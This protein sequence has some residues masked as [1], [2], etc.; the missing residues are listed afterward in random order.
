MSKMGNVTWGKGK[1]RSMSHVPFLHFTMK[2]YYKIL[3][4]EKS[5]TDDDI[6]KAYRKLAHQYHPDK[7]GG[8]EKRFKEI[9]EAYQVIGNSDKRK[10]YDRFGAGAFDEMAGEGFGGFDPFGGN[11]GG[12]G[13]G[14]DPGNMEDMGG[15]SD[16]FDMFF[17][18]LGVKRRKTY[19]KGS[20]LETRVAITLEEAYAGVKKSIAIKTF[21]RCE[22]C[23]GVGH[24]PDVGFDKCG[25]CDGKGE[26]RESKSGFFGS[27]S[28]VRPCAKCFGT[29]QIPKKIC[30]ACLGAGRVTN[31]R[32]VEVAIAAGIS[33]GQLIKLAG[34]GEAGERGAGTGDL[35]VGVTV[36]PHKIFE[37]HGNDLLLRASVSL[38]DVLLEKPL[39]ITTI[40][41]KKLEVAIPADFSLKS[42]MKIAGEGMPRLGGYGCGDLY[43]DL[44]VK[45]PKHLSSVAKKLLEELRRE[46]E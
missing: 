30:V 37:R 7:S 42:K 38:L 5:A 36:A 26:I 13:F 12:F 28:Q 18:G 43:I 23:G 20:D 25:T 21:V 39:I 45:T 16:I 10:T 19:K 15:I 35:Y 44:E 9:N 32:K 2:D 40:G 31:E 24:F 3:G 8:D 6:K 14:F 11:A 4:V 1:R 29:G 33:D 22:K 34:L 17:E 41:G 27:F 46:V